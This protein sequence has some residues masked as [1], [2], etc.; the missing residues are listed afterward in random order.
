MSP[1]T[2]VCSRCGR[3]YWR[4]SGHACGRP[5]ARNDFAPARVQPHPAGAIGRLHAKGHPMP[6]LT[7]LWRALAPRH[8]ACPRCA[9][10]EEEFRAF[11]TEFDRELTEA[12]GRGLA[13]LGAVH[14]VTAAT[15]PPETL[16]PAPRREC[17]ALTEDE[18][19]AFAEIAGWD[20]P[21]GTAV[22]S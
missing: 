13:L 17:C 14:A 1:L 22:R 19:D 8:A 20:G 9:M 3:V 5:A 11:R 6:R 7:A 12:R 2:A 10:L 18:R 16:P 4:G 21:A 15:A